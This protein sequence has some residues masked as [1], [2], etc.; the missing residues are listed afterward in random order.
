[1]VT[2]EFG[3]VPKRGFEKSKAILI[4][5]V[6]LI[7]ILTISSL[8]LF[9]TVNTLQKELS[10]SKDDNSGLQGQINSLQNQIDSL[11]HENEITSKQINEITTQQITFLTDYTEDGTASM[12]CMNETPIAGCGIMNVDG[13]HFDFKGYIYNYGTEAKNIT[14]TV[15][16]FVADRVVAQKQIYI[17]NMTPKSDEEPY[18]TFIPLEA[19]LIY[20]GSWRTWA[21]TIG[22]PY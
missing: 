14:V 19:Q 3:K 16:I 20:L 1:M 15:A 22:G 17:D 10:D 21:F 9:L 2:D 6:A 7:I 5:T 4:V 11:I 18:F 13:A 12:R 8:W